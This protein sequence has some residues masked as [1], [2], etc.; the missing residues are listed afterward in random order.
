MIQVEKANRSTLE[1]A[2]LDNE[3]V[4]VNDSKVLEWLINMKTE[5]MRSIVRDWVLEVE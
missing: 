5:K 1:L 3:I 4:D 2:I